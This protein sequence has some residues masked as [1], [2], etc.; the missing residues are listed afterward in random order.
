MKR[1]DFVVT[2]A[3]LAACGWPVIVSGQQAANSPQVAFML[4]GTSL[5][6]TQWITA[7]QR[8]MRA[9]GAEPGDLPIKYQIR[10]D[11]N[12]KTADALALRPTTV[13]ARADD[14][15]E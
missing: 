2:F 5:D 1:R 4:A 13:L 3:G 10:P 8:R 15:I 12:L 7:F 14:V 6:W 11:I 9:Q